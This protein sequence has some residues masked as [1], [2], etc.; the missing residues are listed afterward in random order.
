[1]M[2]LPYWFYKQ[3]YLHVLSREINIGVHPV[4]NSTHAIAVRA[5]WFRG[6]DREIKMRQI[7][8]WRRNIR[9]R[10]F[11]WGLFW[12]I[13]FFPI[14]HRSQVYGFC[15]SHL[16]IRYYPSHL[17]CHAEV[18]ECFLFGH[19]ATPVWTE[20]REQDVAF[21]HTQLA[22]QGLCEVKNGERMAGKG[23]KN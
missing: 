3:S 18:M 6:V 14:F 5:G 10:W 11:W 8:V 21:A 16:G 12:K 9:R 22:H 7:C 1:M 13:G 15:K 4:N 2:V 20:N 23:K 19:P 17:S